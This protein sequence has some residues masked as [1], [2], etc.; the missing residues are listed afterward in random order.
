MEIL[1]TNI[2]KFESEQEFMQYNER[3]KTEG[4]AQWLYYTCDEEEQRIIALFMC[5]TTNQSL[6]MSSGI[7]WYN[8]EDKRW[9][10]N[11]SR[12][13]EMIGMKKSNVGEKLASLY[14]KGALL[15]REVPA[16]QNPVWVNDIVAR[17]FREMHRANK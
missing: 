11:A 8:T 6:V 17:T 16:D 9:E 10:I 2:V 12:I 5:Q 7:V 4:Y 15:V 13:F 1:K 14:R 3:V